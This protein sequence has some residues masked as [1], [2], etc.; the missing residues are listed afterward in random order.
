V[1]K[2]AYLANRLPANIWFNNILAML[3]LPMFS[4]LY[5]A[6]PVSKKFKS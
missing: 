2:I 6:K 1:C 5:I 3:V 4:A